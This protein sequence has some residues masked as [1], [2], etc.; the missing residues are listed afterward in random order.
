MPG[1]SGAAT[2]AVAAVGSLLLMAVGLGLWLLVER[3]AVGRARNAAA[4]MAAMAIIVVLGLLTIIVGWWEAG[5]IS[6]VVVVLLLGGI[7]AHFSLS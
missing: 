2:V 6:L 7:I 5:V 1:L 3:P 4:A